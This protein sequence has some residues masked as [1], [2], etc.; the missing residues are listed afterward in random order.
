MVRVWDP[1]T[2]NIVRM[3]RLAKGFV[4]TTFLYYF[5]ICVRIL[6]LLSLLFTIVMGAF[7]P[8][9]LLCFSLY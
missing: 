6:L 7:F 4:Q 1:M 9:I 5:L 3:F 8:Y 2:H